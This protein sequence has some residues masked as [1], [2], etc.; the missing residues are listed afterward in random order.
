MQPGKPFFTQ[1]VTYMENDKGESIEVAPHAAM[2]LKIP[3]DEPVA[4]NAI[5]RKLKGE[6]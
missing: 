5:L 2:T 4:E 3:M 1:K 6:S